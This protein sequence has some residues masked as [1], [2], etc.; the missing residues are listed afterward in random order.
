M[1]NCLLAMWLQILST[2]EAV[3]HVTW[4]LPHYWNMASA[5]LLEHGLCLTA[6]TWPLPHYWNM[7]S[8]SLLDPT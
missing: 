2:D 4:P 7:A 1:G 5:S 6:G 8:A 3:L